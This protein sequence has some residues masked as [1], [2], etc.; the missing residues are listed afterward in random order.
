MRLPEPPLLLITDRSQARV[1]LADVL[2]AVFAAGC[3]WA[4]VREK[5]LPAEEQISLAQELLPLAR[6]SA[7]RLTVHGNPILART[8]QVDGAHLSTGGDV[9]AARRVLGEGALIGISVH[10]AAETAA[11]ATDPPDYLIAGPAFA[12]ASKPGYGPA[13]GVAGI[14]AIASRS[15]IPVLAIGGIDP[16]NVGEVIGAGA[17]GIA[18]MGGVMRA[19]DPG[20]EIRELL[21]ALAEARAQPR[22]R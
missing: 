5:D 6:K 22:A 19:T 4:S 12:P 10:A 3:R 15:P 17:S 16:S 21:V 13:L 14:A 7:A 11:F 8:A 20:H 9:A 1:P 18:V 2:A